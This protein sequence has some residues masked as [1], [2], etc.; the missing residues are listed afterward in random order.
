MIPRP[1]DMMEMAVKLI[2]QMDSKLRQQIDMEKNIRCII[3]TKMMDVDMTS[4]MTPEK[5]R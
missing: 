4:M 5:K 3:P 2:V 1:N